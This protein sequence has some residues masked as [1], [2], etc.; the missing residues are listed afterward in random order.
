[1]L[2]ET[3]LIDEGL[4][5]SAGMMRRSKTGT[6]SYDAASYTQMRL[7]H[8]VRPT[9]H[10]NVHLR[11]RRHIEKVEGSNWSLEKPSSE[12]A[13]QMVVEIDL[14][15]T[16]NQPGTSGPGGKVKVGGFLPPW[17]SRG[18]YSR[19]KRPPISPL[20]AEVFA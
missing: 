6:A 18:C 3:R 11:D 20:D 19:W 16:V 1:V 13:H 5:R 4:S 8:Q 12:G 10:E 14:Y 15:I 7:R 9:S 2:I 17:R